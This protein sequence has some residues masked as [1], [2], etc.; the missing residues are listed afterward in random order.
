[1][2]SIALVCDAGSSIDR[3]A[4]ADALE[5][6]TVTG[7]SLEDM[8]SAARRE[9]E[10][11]TYDRVAVVATTA[12]EPTRTRQQVETP[13]RA[14]GAETVTWVDPRLAASRPTDERARL[15]GAAVEAALAVATPR[16]TTPEPADDHVVVVDD[17][18]LSADLATQFPVT[19]VSDA[20]DYRRRDV[21]TVRGS[22]V[23]LLENGAGDGT[24]GV[25]VLV[26]RDGHTERIAADQVVW[27]GYDGDLADARVVHTA[28]TGVL[29]AAVRVARDRARKPVAVDTSRCVVGR[30]GIDGCRACADV[31]PHDAVSIGIDGDGTVEI[32][33]EACTD[34][35]ACLGVCPT[36]ALLSP[37][38]T[39]LGAIGDAT[40][41]ALETAQSDGSSLP[42]VGG[43]SDPVV[44]A[45]TSETV[46]PALVEATATAEE[47]PTVPVPVTAASRVP[48]SML[49]ATVAA[50][51]SGVA[52]VGDPRA[53]SEPLEEAVDDARQL[54]EALVDDAPV[55]GVATT[56]PSAIVEALEAVARDDPLVDD[57]DSIRAHAQTSMALSGTA[58]DSLADGRQ[59]QVTAPS[60]GSVTVAAD[61]CT[62]CHACERLCPTEAFVQPDETTLTFDPSVCTGC[63]ICDACPEDAI[64]VDDQITV[65]LGERETVV[66]AD[67]I[68]CCTECGEPFASAAVL[69]NVR[70]ELEG[71]GETVDES[72]ELC[73]KC[74]R[75]AGATR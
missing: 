52:L 15:V 48:A 32:D 71:S 8:L 51:A 20:A 16:S 12:G 36:E 29:R 62:L 49:C 34:C 41:S 60:M 26:D 65:P 70:S 27:P 23:G 50:G 66:E 1:M 53:P 42:F 54:L 33:A 22:P 61:D 17:T 45:F 69:E 21:R 59:T 14:A 67:D 37:R 30:K 24:G 11:E 57:A 39:D 18:G 64:E 46:L 55:Q 31:C 10:S 35:G 38:G 4:V 25:T 44:I 63:R 9:I 2:S 75:K 72:L 74:R 13:L 47:P 19:L 6:R 73:Q 40:R 43:D 56:E 68:V 5:I 28:A 3:R 7:S 58:A